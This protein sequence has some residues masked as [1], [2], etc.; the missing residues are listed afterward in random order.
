[1]GGTLL[2]ILDT[3][4]WIWYINDPCLL[5]K[6][7]CDQIEDELD[8]DSI[9]VSSISVWELFMLEKS[10]R[11]KLTLSAH[12]WVQKCENLSIFRF[13]P[14][15]NEIARISV[16]LNGDLHKDT[17][18]R[19]ILATALKEGAILI[20]KDNRLQSYPYVETVW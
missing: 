19:I 15:D 4:T 7:A 20:T 2:I 6:Q 17:A 9:L 16:Q 3:H 12:T 8:K 10:G 5:S 11:L 14:V 13:V 1:M 18:D